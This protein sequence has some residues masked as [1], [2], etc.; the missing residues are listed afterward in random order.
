MPQN[1]YL[2]KVPKLQKSTDRRV[3]MSAARAPFS[4]STSSE[5]RKAR[6]AGRRQRPECREAKRSPIKTLLWIDD[7]EPGLTLYKYMFESLGYRVLT[8]SRPKAGLR[9]ATANSIDAV[10]V[11]YE[12]PEMNGGELAATLKKSHPDLPVVMFTGSGLIPSRARNVIDAYCDKAGPRSEL[13][14][15]IRRVIEMRSNPRSATT[16]YAA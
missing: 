8:A 12:M 14:A 16:V 10:I 7:Y 4:A 9:L 5:S 3:W 6:R 11:D 2:D 1:A 15:A 13:E